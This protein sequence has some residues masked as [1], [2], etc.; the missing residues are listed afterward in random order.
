MMPVPGVSRRNFDEHLGLFAIGPRAEHL[1]E[2][3]FAG[4][5]GDEGPRL[6][7]GQVFDDVAAHVVGGRGRQGDGRAD[8][9]ACGGNSP[10]GRN[11]GGNRGPIG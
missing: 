11:R 1:V 8:C 2:E 6:V 3:V 4:E 9:P 10:A 7:Q 5:A